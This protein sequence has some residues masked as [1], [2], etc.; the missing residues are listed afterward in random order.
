MSKPY[1]IC[2]RKGCRKRVYSF[3]RKYCPECSHIVKRERR[4]ELY[5]R[6]KEARN[7]NKRIVE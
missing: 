6:K 3:D 2:A 1:K 4:H 5:L 7:A